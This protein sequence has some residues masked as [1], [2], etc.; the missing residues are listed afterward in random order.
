MHTD[1]LSLFLALK[2]DTVRVKDGILR[3]IWPFNLSFLN[4]GFHA[5]RK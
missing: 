4:A 1:S 5:M 3:P 2:T